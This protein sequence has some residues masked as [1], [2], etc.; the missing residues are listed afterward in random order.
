[1]TKEALKLALEA[2]MEHEGNCE[3]GKEGVDR[4]VKAIAAIKE[5]LAQ[6]A[7]V[8]K[9]MHPELRKMWEDHFDKCFRAQ[10]EEKYAYGTQLMGAMKEQK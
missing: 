2:L 8:Q 10:P 3:L 7:P 9:P 5:A 4:H 1:M 6:P